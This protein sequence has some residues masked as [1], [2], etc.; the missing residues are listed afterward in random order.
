MPRKPYAAVPNGVLFD[1]V[2]VTHGPDQSWRRSDIPCGFKDLSFIKIK[3]RQKTRN[4][5]SKSGSADQWKSL[6][7]VE[8]D[9]SI[10]TRASQGTDANLEGKYRKK[11][12]EICARFF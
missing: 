6:H 5:S 7:I 11:M 2:H 1:D 3:E 12:E 10:Q 8:C 9:Q 4:R